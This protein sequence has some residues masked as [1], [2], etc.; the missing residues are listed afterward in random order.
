VSSSAAAAAFSFTNAPSARAPIFAVYADFGIGNDESINALYKDAAAGGFDAVI[1]A[2]DWAY[3]LD[4]A[5]SET[6]NAFMRSVEPYAATVPYMGTVGNHEAYGTQGGGAFANYAMRQRALK[7]YAGANS[8]SNSSFW[9]SFDTPLIHWVAFSGESWTM[10]AAQIATQA[11][12]VEADLAKVDRAVTPWVVVF[13]HKSYMMD[14][15]TW[16]MYDWLATLKVDVQLSG[17]WHQ[18]TRY[19]PIDSRNNKV[20]IDTASISADKKT[21]TNPAYPVLIVAGAPGDVEVNPKGCDE[22][23]NLYCSGNYGYGWL[24]AINATHLR[25]RWNTTVPVAGSADPT[26]SDELLI[27]KD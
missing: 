14:S 9:Y 18:Y 16:G 6:G 24:Q 15:T 2:G 22:P 23:N 4:D 1:H 21:Y 3:D 12:W 25:W 27:V 17:H 26:F 10:S 20:V 19:P 11:A 5:K 7:Q 13:S 8:G